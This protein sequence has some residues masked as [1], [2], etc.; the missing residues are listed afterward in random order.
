[1]IT[2]RSL[3]GWIPLVKSC[4]NGENDSTRRGSPAW[5]DA[6]GAAARRSFPPD[7]VV[8]IKALA[9]ELPYERK[10]PLSR[11][12]VADLQREA[13]DRG[14]VASIGKTTLWR[15]L[16]EDAIRPWYQRSWIFPRDPLFY[17]KAV[18]VLDL[19][20]GVWCGEPLRD[21][22][23]VVSADEKTGI[24]VLKRG[25]RT[26]APSPGR[27]ILVEH[28]YQR[29]GTFAYLAAW[30]VRRAKVFGRCDET[31]GIVPFGRLVTDVMSQKVYRTARRVFWIVDNGSSHRGDACAQRLRQEWK[32]IIVVHT[33]VHASWLNQVEIYFSVLQRKALTPLDFKSAA[34]AQER[35]MAFQEYYE[36]VAEPFK[37]EFTRRD[38]KALMRRLETKEKDLAKAA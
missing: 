31:T 33:P 12:S 11:L 9:C 7:V 38:L 8:Q 3:S 29:R 4:R 20:E 17:E 18:R 28:E 15:W 2:S 1:L 19:Y 35:I 27:P 16:S 5:P 32:N 13:I 26:V 23:F 22:D 25:H 34:E 6:P 37:W 30:D 24:Q 36:Q 14:I 21:G 10:L